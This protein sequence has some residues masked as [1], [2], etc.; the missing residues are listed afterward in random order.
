MFADLYSYMADVHD[1]SQRRVGVVHSAARRAVALSLS[2][3]DA[4]VVL[5]P[6]MGDIINR[7]GKP[8]L[9]MEGLVDAEDSLLESAAPEKSPHP[10]VLYAGALRKQYGLETLVRGFQAWD[11]PEAELVIYGQGDYAAELTAIA[12]VD[13]RISCHGPVPLAEVVEAERRAWLLVNP[14]PAD[15]EFTQY[16]FPS[17]NMEYLASGSAVLTTR[18]PGM[19]E[20]YLDYVLTVDAPG[21]EGMTE[22]LSKAFAEGLNGLTRRGERGRVFVLEHKNN[23]RQAGR[24]IELA[25]RCRP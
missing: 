19:P 18:L 14:R 1:A 3:L 23:V 7:D 16:S 5:T 22:A 6:Q 24:I 17:K 10:T 13:P 21:S 25:G 15:E 20:E 12:E 9:V 11:E 2:L 4:Y 8:C